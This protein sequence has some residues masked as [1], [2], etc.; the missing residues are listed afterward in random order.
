MNKRNGA[1]EGREETEEGGNE[2]RRKQ[3][4]IEERKG[5]RKINVS[6][7]SALYCNTE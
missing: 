1:A 6:K 3:G 5:E 2:E 4:R 7:T